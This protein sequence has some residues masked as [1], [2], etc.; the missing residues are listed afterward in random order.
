MCGRNRTGEHGAPCVRLATRSRPGKGLSALSLVEQARR[1]QPP[2]HLPAPASR[3]G[4]C[5]A[6]SRQAQAQLV[7]SLCSA[8][9]ACL[10]TVQRC[11]HRS[12]A[13]PTGHCPVASCRT[14]PAD[15]RTV[16]RHVQAGAARG[17]ASAGLAWPGLTSPS[18]TPPSATRWPRLPGRWVCI[19]HP[20]S[21][22]PPGDSSYQCPSDSPGSRGS[23]GGVSL[24]FICHP[25]LASQV[26]SGVGTA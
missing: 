20:C 23:V 5:P 2:A 22:R 15:A 21:C 17:V 26:L 16:S 18:H 1:A 14:V 7:P 19:L 6:R 8:C 24:V 12:R 9:Q 25:A 4:A 11:T 3:A 13:V 10:D